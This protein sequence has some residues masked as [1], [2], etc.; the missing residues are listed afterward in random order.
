MFLV[1]G[2]GGWLVSCVGGFGMHAFGL[3]IKEAFGF[4]LLFWEFGMVVAMVFFE[5]GKVFLFVFFLSFLLHLFLWVLGLG[6]WAFSTESFDLI[7]FFFLYFILGI[8]GWFACFVSQ[9]YICIYM[10]RI[11]TYVLFLLFWEFEMKERCSC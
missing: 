3:F 11:D 1:V 6:V 9:V 2:N 5:N 8:K 10:L 7:D 4:S